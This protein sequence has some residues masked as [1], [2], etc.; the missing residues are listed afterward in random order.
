MPMDALKSEVTLVVRVIGALTLPFGNFLMANLK[1][2]IWPF[3][4]LA[5]LDLII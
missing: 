4:F 3:L 1:S 2:V 5:L